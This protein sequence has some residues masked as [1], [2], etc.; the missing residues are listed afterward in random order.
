MKPRLVPV[1]LIALLASG[2]ACLQAEDWPRFRGPN[3]SG[4][5]SSATIPMSWSDAENVKWKAVLPGPGASSPIVIGDK[6]LLSCYTGYGLDKK[7]PGDVS[8]LRRMLLCYNKHD[9]S[10]L[11]QSEVP[12]THD[13]D[14]YQGFITEHGYASCTPATDGEHVFVTFGKTGAVAFDLDGK[15]LWLTHVG[16]ASDPFKWGGGGSCLVHN[17]LVIVNATITDKAI[18][19]L[20][21]SDG[22]EV[23]RY[24]DPKLTNCWSTPIIVAVDGHDEL[25][26]CIPGKIVGLHPTTGEELWSAKSPIAN[27]TCASVVE[28]EGIVFA[29]GGRA[30]DAIAVRCG[31]L[32][33]V[34]STHTVWQ[35]KLRS[36]IGTPIVANDR[37][38]WTSVGIAFCASCADGEVVYKERLPRDDGGE[39]SEGG[40]RRPTGDYASAIKVGDMLLLT[41]RSG[42]THIVRPTEDFQRITGNTFADDE[43]PFNATPAVSD[44][45]LFIRSDKRLYCISDKREA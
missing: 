18:I 26:T 44:G 12:S 45:E 4:V 29:M 27:T 5:S 9:G 8:Q 14:P 28:H 10:L 2:V 32:G 34:S 22:S 31:G 21:K 43:G 36:G 25:V 33:D 19:A 42:T 24:A 35:E 16:A 37:L 17:D 40:R 38:Y 41:T 23:W 30:G 3:G 13:E 1:S 39:K 11:W 15:K 7:E 6:V 20:N